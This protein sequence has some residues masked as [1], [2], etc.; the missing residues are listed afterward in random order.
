[1]KTLRSLLPL[2]TIFICFNF[3][4]AQEEEMSAKKYDN[5]EYYMVSYLKF[6][7]GKVGEANKIIDEYFAPSGQEAGVPGPV[8]HLDF[9]TGEW[10]MIVIWH[11]KDGVESLNWEM[12]PDDVKWEKAFVKLVGGEEKGKEISRNWESY[13]KSSK[14]EISR[15]HKP[16]NSKNM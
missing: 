14:T 16:K 15:K 5:P 6:H 7:P 1:M 13:I 4:S 3:L 8:M 2:F 11:M 10:D 12:S 9:I